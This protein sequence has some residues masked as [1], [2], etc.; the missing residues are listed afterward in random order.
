MAIKFVDDLEIHAPKPIKLTQNLKEVL[1][2]QSKE[3]SEKLRIRELYEKF[4]EYYDRYYE[5]QSNN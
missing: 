4:D 5:G 2:R 1:A 3:I